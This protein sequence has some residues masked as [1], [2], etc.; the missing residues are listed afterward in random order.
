MEGILV[1]K[2]M[3]ILDTLI[4]EHFDESVDD[5]TLERIISQIRSNW[6]SI[7]TERMQEILNAEGFTDLDYDS[8][9]D[10]LDD[11]TDKLSFPDLED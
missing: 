11:L 7:D 10:F 6:D 1:D 9:V 8:I 4:I 5:S 3:R 2:L